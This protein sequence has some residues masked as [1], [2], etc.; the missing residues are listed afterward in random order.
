MTTEIQPG[1]KGYFQVFWLAL[2]IG[3]VFFLPFLIMDKGLFVYYG[4]FNVQQIPFYQMCHDM[5]RSG[6]TGWNWYTDLGANFVGSYAFYLLGSPFF[7]LTIPFPSEAVPYLMAPLL[8]LK[9]AVAAV[10][11]FGYIKRFV[12]NPGFAALGALMYAFSGYS[13]YNIFFNHFHEVIAFFPLLLI[14]LEEF[15]VNRRRGLFALTVALNAVVNYYFFFGEVIFVVL[16]FFLRLGD[17]KNFRV[18]I[19]RF[20]LLALEAV[21]GLLLSAVLLLPGLMAI[22]DNP[23]TDNF[24]MGW[25][26]IFYG[27]VQRYGLILQSLFYPPDI[28]AYPNFFPDSNAKWSSVSLFLP[29]VSLSGVIAFIRSRQGHWARRIFLISVLT[30]LVPIL[31]SAFS[32]FNTAYYARWFYMPLLIMA[33][34]TCSSLEDCTFEQ[35]QSGVGWTGAAVVAF[36]LIGVFPSKSG[37]DV[38]F[39]QLPEYPERLLAYLLVT[40]VGLILTACLVSLPRKGFSAR[41]FL[42][43]ATISL[44]FMIVVT[45]VMMLMLGKGNATTVKRVVDMGLQGEFT[46]ITADTDDVYRI[47]MYNKDDTRCMDNFPMFWQIPTI[48]AFHSVVPGSIFTFY[49]AIGVERSVGSRPDLKYDALRSLTS[50]KYL[51][52]YESIEEEPDIDG[53]TYL[54][55][56]NGFKI[57]ENENYIPM[58]FTY[59]YYVDDETFEN[60]TAT[61]KDRLLL[62]ALH[63]SDEQIEAHEDILD[64]LPFSEEPQNGASW[65]ASAA[66]DRRETVC[67]TFVR[68][69]K[70]FSASIYTKEEELVFF[71]IPWE[72]GWSATVNGEKVE[73]ENVSDGFMAVRVPAG[74][75]EI[76]FDY[77]TPGLTAGLL[78]TLAA[79]GGLVLYLVLLTRLGRLRPLFWG[80]S[81]AHLNREFRLHGIR[82]SEDY[83]GSVVQKARK[84]QQNIPLELPAQPKPAEEAPDSAPQEGD[85]P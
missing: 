32:A 63:L 72:S 18:D 22:M 45:S 34:M 17:K 11:S 10:T 31:N 77:R 48:Q 44:S 83:A 53:F 24:L 56:E 13:I 61:K 37:E 67:D 84:A 80:H 42:R 50:C 15:V 75:A 27:N 46:T 19:R 47:D 9:M 69:K 36:A 82:L 21:I 74:R 2:L 52:C 5:I 29:M 26:G 58:G 51:L 14:G 8:M 41:K 20:L 39:G 70:G 3:F 60:Y 62:A 55:T 81:S 43:P 12:R 40:V 4:D 35:L 85:A 33:M 1:R 66:N 28:P 68:D 76:R 54:T 23:R 59:D 6:E 79:A 78:I 57:Y 64:P 25:S 7:W 38:V 30:S 49:D 16:Y 71:S 73:I 65:L